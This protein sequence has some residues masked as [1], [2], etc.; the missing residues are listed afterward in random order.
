[1]SKK[2]LL[3]VLTFVLL[4]ASGLF[5][6]PLPIEACS[7]QSPVELRQLHDLDVAGFGQVMQNDPSPCPPEGPQGGTCTEM[8][9]GQIAGAPFGRG[10]FSG[11]LVHS[12]G[13]GGW[14]NGQFC[15]PVAGTLTLSGA[16]RQGQL[17]LAVSGTACVSDRP[18]GGCIVSVGFEVLGQSTGIFLGTSGQGT[19]TGGLD[20][21][22]S[23]RFLAHGTFTTD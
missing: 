16:Q 19:L 6:G 10:S 15:A 7:P 12:W 2:H 21:S 13:Q 3:T 20:E 4:C 23:V 9:Q 17:A 8:A 1:M 22:G 14:V 11:S 5:G 18:G